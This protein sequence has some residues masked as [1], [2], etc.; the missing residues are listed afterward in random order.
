MAYLTD[1]GRRPGSPGKMVA[2]FLWRLFQS[3]ILLADDL[4]TAIEDARR[5]HR[6]MHALSDLPLA[7]LRDIG[8]ERDAC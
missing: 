7:Q 1:V 5:E 4:A 8:L 2:N 3:S 6:I